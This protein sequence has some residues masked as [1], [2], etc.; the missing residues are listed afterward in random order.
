MILIENFNFLHP[1]ELSVP[2]RT[3]R[4]LGGQGSANS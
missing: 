3:F 4:M 2:N 1:A